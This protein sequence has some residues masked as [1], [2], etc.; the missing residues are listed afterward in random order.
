MGSVQVCRMSEVLTAAANALAGTLV[1]GIPLAFSLEW[2]GIH[3]AVLDCHADGEATFPALLEHM[4][5]DR[6]APGA[7]RG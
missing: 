7:S 4:E 6:L 3:G 5:D 1:R 2:V